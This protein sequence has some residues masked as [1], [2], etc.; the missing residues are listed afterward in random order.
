MGG[1][2][3]ET[4][5]GRAI[6]RPQEYQPKEQLGRGGKNRVNASG[7]AVLWEAPLQASLAGCSGG[8]FNA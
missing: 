2:K 7:V 8:E 3:S 4:K 5:V 6:P 1:S